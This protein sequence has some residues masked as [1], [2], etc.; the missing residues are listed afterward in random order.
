MAEPTSG[1]RAAQIQAV[2]DL[3]QRLGVEP[4]SVHD[5]LARKAVDAVHAA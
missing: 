4:E 2:R 3:A 1:P 5:E